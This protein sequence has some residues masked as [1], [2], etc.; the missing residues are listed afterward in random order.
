MHD[1]L[2]LAQIVLLL[3]VAVMIVSAFRRFSMSPVLGYIIAGVIIGPHG[4]ALLSDVETTRRVAEFGIVFL[5]FIIGLELPLAKLRRIRRHVFGFGFAQVLLTGLLGG[6]IAHLAGANAAAAIII[7]GGLAFSS[8]AIVLQLIDESSMKMTQPGRLC[9]AVLILQDLAVIPLLV[10]VPLLAAPEKSILL[11]LSEASLKAAVG[12]G[13]IVLLGRV[14]LRAL[15]RFIA[16][17]DH[18][19]LFTATTL[20]VVLGL[21]YISALCGLS[22]ALGAFMAG[23]LIAE[24]EF[25]PQV[26][27]DILPFKRLLLGLFFIAVGMSV[28]LALVQEKAVAIAGM[29]LALIAGKSVVMYALCRMFR[30][31]H[32]T[33]IYTSLL[34][35]QGGEFAFVLF[36]LASEHGLLSGQTAQAMLASAAISMALTPLLDKAGQHFFRRLDRPSLTSVPAPRDAM[37]LHDHVVVCGFGRVGR[38][39][40]RLLEAERIPYMGLDIDAINIAELN[41]EGMQVHFGDATRGI[42]LRWIGI[43]R[44]R[45]LIITHHDLQTSLQTIRMAR[46]LSPS[47]PIIARAR[48]IDEVLQ[49]EAAGA[50]LAVAEHFETSLQLGGA[51]LKEI[52]VPELEIARVL[53]SFRAEDYALTRRIRG[54]RSESGDSGDLIL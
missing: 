9:V 26:E 45:A 46:S 20:L 31:P 52:G 53:G 6:V 34:L 30:F 23:L 47:L 35:A 40:A 50:N 16:M 4:F 36:S 8:T 1:T 24:T 19:E 44:A 37:E 3:A 12:L 41:T 17:H 27:A 28:D 21:A 25:R 32:A 2:H 7:G 42:V 49:M 43:T 33:S 39:V 29:T 18:H 54:E 51:A 10:L 11:A 5:L 13:A 15:F 22:P 14:G 48:N 38:V